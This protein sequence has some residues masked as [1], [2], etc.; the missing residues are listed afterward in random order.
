M[1]KIFITRALPGD[2]LAP[3]TEIGEVTVAAYDRAMT[4][5]ELCAGVA[6]ADAVI[7]TLNDRVGPEVLDAAGPQLRLVANVAVGYDNLDVAAITAHGAV[8]TNT[9]GVLVD[10]TADLTIAL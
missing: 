1:A 3:L 9:P 8:A 7:T 4:P 2:V 5:A 6:G 10:A